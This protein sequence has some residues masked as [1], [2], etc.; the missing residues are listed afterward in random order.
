MICNVA[1]EVLYPIPKSCVV[2]R[3]KF[4]VGMK[5][6]KTSNNITRYYNINEKEKII[7]YV[8]Q[9]IEPNIYKVFL[10]NMEMEELISNHV[11]I[12]IK[13]KYVYSQNISISQKK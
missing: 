12:C 6:K 8:E 1:N 11:E 2:C 9:Q 10:L 5:I 3:E 4:Y 13:H 7:L